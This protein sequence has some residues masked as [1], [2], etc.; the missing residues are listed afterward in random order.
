MTGL[1][2]LTALDE[3][4]NVLSRAINVGP[5]SI[6]HG[7][8]E[9]KETILRS[10]SRSSINHGKRKNT[11][12]PGTFCCMRLSK[13]K[14]QHRMLFSF[15]RPR[16][17][18][19]FFFQSE[20]FIGGNGEKSCQR[21]MENNKLVLYEHEREKRTHHLWMRGHTY[22]IFFLNWNLA[23]NLPE[24]VLSWFRPALLKIEFFGSPFFAL[25]HRTSCVG[26][27]LRAWESFF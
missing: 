23:W 9:R 21:R 14:E 16:R 13:K 25:M 27:Q 1:L 5:R 10:W 19:F 8:A 26:Y 12:R 7:A 4:Q 24:L 22:E 11:N 6:P 2:P 3:I 15:V 18:P 20:R 17:Q